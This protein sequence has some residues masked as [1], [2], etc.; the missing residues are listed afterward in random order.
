MKNAISFSVL[1]AG[2]FSSAGL[3][4]LVLF[5]EGKNFTQSLKV[6]IL[7]YVFSV[8]GGFMIQSIL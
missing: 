1:M 3:G 8:L 7:L 5:K 6:L 4:L 2:L